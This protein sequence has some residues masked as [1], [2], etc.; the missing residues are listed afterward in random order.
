MIYNIPENHEV[1]RTNVK[2]GIFRKITYFQLT[3]TVCLQTR[4]NDSSIAEIS[5]E[6][7]DVAHVM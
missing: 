6:R 4:A 1:L 3:A 5:F 7:N 2:A